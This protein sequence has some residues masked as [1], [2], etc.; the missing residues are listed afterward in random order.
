MGGR[1]GLGLWTDAAVDHADSATLDRMPAARPQLKPGAAPG[2]ARRQHPAARRRPAPRRGDQ[3]PRPAL[4]RLVDA[5]TAP[6]TGGPCCGIARAARHRGSPSP[7]S[8]SGCSSAPACSTTRPR[9]ARARSAQPGRPRPAGPRPRGRVPRARHGST[10]AWRCSRA[11]ERPS[12]PCR[13]G[14]RRVGASVDDIARGCRRRHRGRR[15][16]RHRRG[17]ADVAPAGPSPEDVGPAAPTPPSAQRGG[18]A[19]GCAAPS[20]AAAATRISTVLCTA[21]RD[22]RATSRP[23]GPRRRRTPL[24]ARARRH[25]CGRPA[26]AARPLVLRTL[27]RP[28]PRRPRPGVA[29][30]RGPAD[31]A[32][33]AAGPPRA[34]WCS[35]RQLPPRPHSGARLPRRRPGA[36]GR[37][38]HHRDRPGRRSDAAPRSWTMHPS[39]AARGGR[40]PA[41]SDLSNPSRLAS[42]VPHRSGSRAGP[43]C[44]RPGQ[45][46]NDRH[47]RAPAP[48]RDPH[49]QARR[50]AARAR[51]P[52]DPRVW[53]SG[54]GADPPRSWQPRC[55]PAPPS[56]C[57]GCSASSRAGR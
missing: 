29:E 25:R 37:G 2:L 43:P 14:A 39:A 23:A 10:V 13:C 4:R 42:R 40:S 57:S 56:S 46:D 48:R 28:A 55:R 32:A 5:S 47:D 26:R 34:T 16:P 45:R 50:A 21:E 30:R 19:G 27:P 1:S 17:P 8:C 6:A 12:C 53:A 15:G 36:A 9:P 54:S 11:G 3:R 35:R 18:R 20:P 31:R 52:R 33:P 7:T 38:R 24:R 41:S 51:R 22:G 49:R 44:R